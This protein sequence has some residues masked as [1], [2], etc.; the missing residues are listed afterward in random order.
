MTPARSGADGG[1]AHAGGSRTRGPTSVP[2]VVGVVLLDSEHYV[3]TLD[4]ENPLSWVP[5]E[6]LGTG[7]LSHPA[8]WSRPALFAVARGATAKAAEERRPEA[9]R[10]VA[11]A[12]RRLD[13]RCRIIVGTCG[14][15]VDAWP[16]LDPPP[17][18]PTV[19]SA[20]DVLDDALRSSRC[21]VLVLTMTTE[22]GRRSLAGTPGTSRVRVVGMDGAGDW[23]EMDRPDWVHHRRWSEAG[24]EAG[25][26]EV[27]ERER[28]AGGALDG[29][30]CVLLV[31][32]ILPQ[33]TA[34]VREYTGAPI[35]H[36]GT[37]AET[38]LSTS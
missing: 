20:L 11:D 7:F 36:V 21:D 23:A 31:C 24:L 19:L 38:L 15:F 2:D 12:V 18:T 4:W 16:A 6:G 5:P 33:F 29:I 17:A 3:E 10:G 34:V 14:R 13:G 22:S 37:L 28:V 25:L 26:R 27:L 9:I 32:T 30:G 8:Y 1:T 35:V